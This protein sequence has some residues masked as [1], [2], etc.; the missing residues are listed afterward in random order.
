MAKK[1]IEVPLIWTKSRQRV[2]VSHDEAVCQGVRLKVNPSYAMK[3]E[4]NVHLYPHIA[5]E[6]DDDICVE[7]FVDMDVWVIQDGDDIPDIES[8]NYTMEFI[9]GFTHLSTTYYV[10]GILVEQE[11]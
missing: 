11:E 4:Y 8:D 10:Y 5:V 9:G 7:D 1:L 3:G 2:S 6:M